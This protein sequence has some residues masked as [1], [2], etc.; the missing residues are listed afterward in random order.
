MTFHSTDDSNKT[1]LADF[2]DFAKPDEI[3]FHMPS[4]EVITDEDMVVINLAATIE[5]IG[6]A[7]NGIIAEIDAREDVM[8]V[9]EQLGIPQGED[10]E[11]YW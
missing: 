6:V 10:S 3:P 8:S 2:A 5:S 1:A 9:F 11:R 4:D 7:E